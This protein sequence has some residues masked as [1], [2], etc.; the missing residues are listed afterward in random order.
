MA[1]QAPKLRLGHA[2]VDV[3]PPL[4]IPMGGY[5]ARDHGCEEIEDRLI[6]DAVYLE[7]GDVKTLWMALDLISVNETWGRQVR[8]GVDRR[9]GVPWDRVLL[10]PS[11]THFGPATGVYETV[12]DEAHRAWLDELVQR[13]IDVAEEAAAH[14][15]DVTAS[16]GRADVS[17]M[18]Y[19]RRLRR[20][21]GSCCMVL[22][23]P[24]PEE[25]EGLTFGPIEPNLTL[26]RFDKEDGTPALIL[27]SAA[28]HPVIGGGNYYG[29][30]ADYPG[31]VRRI[32]EPALGAPVAFGLG[33]AG[34]LVPIQRGPGQ[35]E[36]IGRFLAGAALEAASTVTPLL[37]DLRV[38]HVRVELPAAERMGP[39]EMQAEIDA[40]SDTVERLRGSDDKAA[41]RNAQ[42]TH[43][44]L[45]AVADYAKVA[46]QGDTIPFEVAAIGLGEFGIV[47]L[48]GEIFVETGLHVQARSPFP[49]TLVLSLAN[50]AT[51]YL[52]TRTAFWEGGYETSVSRMS[53]ESEAAACDVANRLLVEVWNEQGAQGTSQSVAS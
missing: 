45:Q 23:L 28:I 26:L 43:R 42:E 46:G 44:R 3:T 52:P 35:R 49:Q 19:N 8:D 13:L 34:N 51:G 48:P 22:R 41:L 20:P 11:H 25:E 6:A 16:I 38:S 17:P 1:N 14:P 27:Y 31:V 10:L 40:V 15:V 2:R 37:S 50:Q 33:T 30:S 47:T 9:V 36:R 7:Q 4:G 39:E 18:V 29:I 5:A 24:L 12:E 32:L 53:E 21:D